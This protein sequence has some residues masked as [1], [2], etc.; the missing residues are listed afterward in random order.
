MIL[1]S[2]PARA[3]ATAA[4]FVLVVLA[5][6]S[7]TA[8]SAASQP[9][10][11]SLTFDDGRASE[12]AARSL[13]SAH[14]MDATFY[15]NSSKLGTDSDYMTWAQVDDLAADGNEIGGH[16]AFHVDLTR[17]DP[18]EAKR[19]VCNDRV[20]L[21]NRGYQ[22][23]S[24]AYPFGAY[25]ASAE[26]IVSDCGFNSARTTNQFVPPPAE[27]IPPQDPFAIRVAGAAGSGISLSTL[28]SYV[29][30]VEQNGGGWAPLVFH[31][32]CNAC[33]SN[34]ISQSNLTAFLDWL[35]PRAANGTIVKTVGDVIGG[36]V[37]AAVAGPPPPPPPNGT[38]A[39][40][41][42]SL[43]QLSSGNTA[44]DCWDFDSWGNNTYSWSR[45]TDAH[46]GS[47][48]ERVDVSRYVNGDSKLVVMRDLGFCTPTVT[49]GHRYRLTAWYKSSAKSSFVAFTRD[50]LGGYYYWATSPD[51]PAS[52]TWTQASWVSPVVPGG[53]NGVS[54]GL[55]ISSN[56]F[57]T[58]DDLGFDD[59][60]A[61]GTVDTTPPTVALTSPANGANVAGTTTISVTASDNTAVDHVDYLVDGAVVGTQTSG[62]YTLGW[63]SRTVANGTHTITARAVDTSGNSATSAAV[64]VSVSNSTVNLLQNPSLESA[65]GATPTCWALGGYGTNTFTWTRTSDA[66][67]G[68]FGEKL[69][70][71]SW[72]D[73]DRKLVNTQDSGT[74]APAVTPGHTYTVSVYYKSNVQPRIF[75]YYRSSSGAWTYWWSASFPASSS[76]ARASWPTPA[77]PSGATNLSVGMGLSVVGSVTMD[78]FALSDDAPVD[79]APPT[80]TIT[81]NGPSE[82]SGCASGWYPAPVDVTLS[83]TD[84]G[85]SGLKEIRYTTDGSDPTAS[86]GTVY[87]GPFSVSA[88]STV[89]YRAFDNADNAEAVKSQLIRVDAVA[90]TVAI[91]AP[92]SGATVSGTVKITASASD[93]GGSGVAKVSFYIDGTLVATAMQ[94]PYWTQW[95]TRKSTKGQHTL[96][97]VAQ[98]NAG[99]TKTST[100]LTVTVA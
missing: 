19:E 55:T 36:A 21:L 84:S 15:V 17:T 78:D 83:A 1:R 53:V 95:N 32:I 64:S 13:L 94:A 56:G 80:T 60:A 70:V 62:P 72:T 73:G 63:D 31:Q 3:E 40:L 46:T 28:E 18:T 66:H 100:A 47:Y 9:T 10:I 86:S 79:T 51:F 11:V 74:C 25:N 93:A 38:N 82:S 37:K 76:W 24:F 65:A 88:T 98:D 26:K 12:Y 39:L 99:N 67:S 87:S 22:A 34:A 91:T 50:G 35:Q 92:A 16:T 45:T 57:L 85:G 68:S 4:G 52:S 61:S 7:P 8:A 23:R 6:S 48:A 97:A 69:D 75:A 42:A 5:S 27:T 44:P 89:K 71:T 30:K 58:V 20:N 96:T 77:V 14:G 54:F 33:D 29:T 59:A 49:P 43:E 41:N 90:P 81:C 2:L